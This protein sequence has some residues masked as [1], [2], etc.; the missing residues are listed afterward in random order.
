[1]HCLVTDEEHHQEDARPEVLDQ[2]EF[3]IFLS[4]CWQYRMSGSVPNSR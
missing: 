2:M 3:L 1:M 4:G